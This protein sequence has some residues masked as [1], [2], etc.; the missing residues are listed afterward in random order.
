MT[1]AASGR[2]RAATAAGQRIGA[3]PVLLEQIVTGQR[4]QDAP[5]FDL[6]SGLDTSY[7]ETLEPPRTRTDHATHLVINEK[8]SALSRMSQIG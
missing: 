6:R 7:L 8:F 1:E 3:P 5:A 4:K 2:V